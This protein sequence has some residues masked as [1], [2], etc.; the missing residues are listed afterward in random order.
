MKTEGDIYLDTYEDIFTPSN[1]TSHITCLWRQVNDIFITIQDWDNETNLDVYKLRPVRDKGIAGVGTP[2]SPTGRSS[3]KAKR[4]RSR[5]GSNA[6]GYGSGYG[7]DYG[8]SGSRSPRGGTANDSNDYMNKV[9]TF[10]LQYN[11]RIWQLGTMRYE[12]KFLMA[13]GAAQM[14]SNPQLLRIGFK[15]KIKSISLMGIY[16]LYIF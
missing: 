11:S 9:R 13:I 14:G 5:S 7:S 15:T 8:G 2:D 3:P 16:I 1:D 6:S 4:K 10:S 12:K